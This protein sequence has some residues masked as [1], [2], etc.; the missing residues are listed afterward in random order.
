V[1]KAK[2]KQEL[3]ERIASFA[4]L[5]LGM[6]TWEMWKGFWRIPVPAL[7]FGI[8]VPLLMLGVVLVAF[9]ILGDLQDAFFGCRYF[10][11]FSQ[12]IRTFLN[13]YTAIIAGLSLLLALMTG[14]YSI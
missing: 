4:G 2:T 10:F 9:T 1:K 7:E 12:S 5:M 8:G 14:V 6:A 11:D 3:S 13:S